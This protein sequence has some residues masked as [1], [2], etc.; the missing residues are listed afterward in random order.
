MRHAFA[1]YFHRGNLNANLPYTIN[2]VGK[3]LETLVCLTSQTNLV[4][5]GGMECLAGFGGTPTKNLGSGYTRRAVLGRRIKDGVNQALLG[6]ETHSTS[7]I[8]RGDNLSACL[9]YTTESLFNARGRRSQRSNRSR[10]LVR[11]P[12]P[13]QPDLPFLNEFSELVPD[14]SRKDETLI[15]SSIGHRK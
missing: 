12:R 1:F 11:I 13:G 14:L 7:T 9:A 5:A 8:C 3:T 6:C 15:S 10:F 2:F 4:D